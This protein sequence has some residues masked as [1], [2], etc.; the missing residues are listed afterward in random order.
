MTF[1]EV[2]NNLR[3]S[4]LS[5]GQ[6]VTSVIEAAA[7]LSKGDAWR[8]SAS[9]AN[10]LEQQSSDALIQVA[11][12]ALLEA[13]MDRRM[14]ELST[15]LDSIAGRDFG[16]FWIRQDAA[17]EL[18]GLLGEAQSARF[19]YPL[20][21]RPALL[22][23][24][25]RK[26]QLM[27]TFIEYAGWEQDNRI[28]AQI[29]AILDLDIKVSDANPWMRS[30]QVAFDAELIMP[31]FGFDMS[32]AGDVPEST[33]SHLGI[34]GGRHGRLSSESVAI[35]DA[36][37]NAKGR[38]VLAVTEGALFRA[39]G[40][41]AI[42][43]EELVHSGRLQAVMG[44]GPSMMFQNTSINTALLLLSSKGT[45]HA[46]I[47][48]INLSDEQFAS[49]RERGRLEIRKG[50][51]WS[52]LPDMELTGTEAFARDIDLRS[53]RE[54]GYTLT[55]DR[56]LDRHARDAIDRLLAKSDVAELADLVEM[57]RPAALTQQ[58]DGEYVVLEAAPADIADDGNVVDPS[59][60]I[61]VDRMQ[62][63]KASNQMLRPG[64]VLIAFKGAVGKIG[65]VPD[66]VPAEG[67]STIWAAGQSLM[68]LR[69]KGRHRL[70]PRVLCEYLSDEVVQEHLK[71]LA[72][73][74]A[75]QTIA[76]KDLKSLAI[77][78]PD[79]ETQAKVEAAVADRQALYRRIEQLEAQITMERRSNW[80]HSELRS[81]QD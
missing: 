30:G 41:E 6:I 78:L 64:D 47:R 67:S 25:N 3:G 7:N 27:P 34:F 13:P 74:S 45:S 44:I 23:A 16:E 10:N 17:Q 65:I 24:I 51:D 37:L 46:T 77:P 8:D 54:E 52:Q 81:P 15:M 66:D 12:K 68:I 19:S 31:P 4:P 29:A 48:F 75:I 71:S 21:L 58:E 62:Y 63:R 9:I 69:L 5:T 20:S 39:V 76:M 22:F 70:S 73:G 79:K 26:N 11:A 1:Q 72:G 57:I 61:A 42:A 33:L 40:V 2:L 80:P 38:A 60:K 35:A 49:R 55:V 28:L 53:I 14:S 18:L 56:Y 32:R 36:L 50:V 43:R 59:R